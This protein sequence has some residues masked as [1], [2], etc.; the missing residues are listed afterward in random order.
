MQGD[1]FGS[2]NDYYLPLTSKIILMGFFLCHEERTVCFLLFDS[3]FKPCV[4][5]TNFER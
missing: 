5:G 1:N 2:V 3:I 4:A